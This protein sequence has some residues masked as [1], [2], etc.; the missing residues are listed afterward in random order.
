MTSHGAGNT[1]EKA[2]RSRKL[3]AAEDAGAGDVVHKELKATLPTHKA[4]CSTLT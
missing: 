1:A 4:V 3:Q 2:T